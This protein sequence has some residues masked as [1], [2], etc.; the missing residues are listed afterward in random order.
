MSAHITQQQLRAFLA[1]ARCRSFTQAAK[2][3]AYSQSAISL[4]VKTLESALGTHLFERCGQ[5]IELTPSGHRLQGPAAAAL[6][7]LESLTSEL[8]A[9]MEDDMTALTD[10]RSAQVISVQVGSE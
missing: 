6:E 9:A 10:S 8:M 4:H 2:M 3:L 7:R 1:V 5:Q